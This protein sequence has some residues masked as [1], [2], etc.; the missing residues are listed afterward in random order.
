MTSST[1]TADAQVFDG[2]ATADPITEPCA[3]VLF[4][5]SGDLARRMVVPAIFRLMRRGLLHPD[6]HLIGYARTKW[7]NEEF[8]A[9]VREA[10]M[11]QAAPGD[12]EAWPQFAARLFYLPGKYSDDDVQGY[13]W[14]ADMLARCD[15]ELHARGRRLFYLATPPTEFAPILQ[16]LSETGLAGRGYRPPEDGWGRAIIEKPFGRDLASARLLNAQI[17]TY[18]NE[19]DVCRIDHFLGKEAVQNLFAFRFANAI[20]EPVWN[21]NYID[22]VQITAVET[23]GVEGRGRYYETAGALRDML[24]NHLLQLCALICIEPPAE[25]NS[26][27]VRNEKVKVLRAVRRIKPEEV[28]SSAVRGQYA[29]GDT[30]GRRVPAYREESY[31]APD[32]T[33]ETYAALKIYIQNLRWAGVPFYLRTGKRL[34]ARRTEIAVEFKPVPHTPCGCGGCRVCTAV[35]PRGQ[36]IHP[37]PPPRRASRHARREHLARRGTAPPGRGQE[38]GVRDATAHGRA[39]LLLFARPGSG[40]RAQRIRAPVARRSARR[41]DLLR[42]RRRGRGGLGDRRACAGALGGGEAVGLPQLPGRLLRPRRRRRTAR[43]RR[44]PLAR[45]E[46]RECVPLIG[47]MNAATMNDESKTCC[48]QSRVHRSSFRWRQC[49]L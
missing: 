21:R 12:E 8:R 49:W 25:W 34:A 13:V 19:H 4:G 23:L 28:E 10:V 3:I 27:A 16:R 6:F 7:T 32:S 40:G 45:P 26:N 33:V 43:T 36:G 41:P 1:L 31:V 44:S 14:L 38:A 30:E 29:S 22:H 48:F 24:Q 37:P 5:A 9:S 35:P 2:A 17:A 42:A 47:T 15:R 39:R 11:S 18:F 20:F 46:R